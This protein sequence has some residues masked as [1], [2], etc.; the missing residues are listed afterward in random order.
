MAYVTLQELIDRFGDSEL[1]TLA[2]PDDIGGTLDSAAVTRACEDASGEADGYIA[3]AGYS[4]PLS[5]T[6][7][8]VTAYVAD[9]A[10][11]RLYD[12]HAPD[13]ITR[14]YQDAIKFFRMLA[15]GKVQLG[16]QEPAS[17]AG[18]AEFQEGRQV[19]NGGGF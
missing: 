10:R 12:D 5:P 19:F 16:V 9:M 2:P 13:Q 1:A 4:T 14:R 7:A 6:P 8:I 15:E 18:T 11:Y 3:A 17:T